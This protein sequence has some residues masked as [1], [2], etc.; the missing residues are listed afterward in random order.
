MIPLTEDRKVLGYESLGSY[1]NISHFV[2]TRRGGCSKDAYATFNCSPFSGDEMENVRRNQELLFEATS[3]KPSEL[4]IPHQ[5]H[6]VRNLVI[7]RTFLSLPEEERC[8]RLEGI[9][10]LMT[11]VPGYCICISTADCI[12][13]LLYDKRHQAIAAVHAGWRGTVNFIVGHTLE[14]MRSVYGTSGEEVVACI[15]PG[16]SLESFEVGYEVYEA[17]RLNSFD[18]SRISRRNADTGKYHI[19][20]WETNRQQ[21]LDF[22]VPSAQIEVAG[23][24]TYIHHEEFFSARR[25]GIASG[26]ILSGIKIIH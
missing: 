16:I 4:I 18:M 10:A 3:V 23:I 25:L 21:L 13:I 9:D 12:P 19:D 5:T 6:G 15:G 11:D 20:L 24:C 8:G 2:T 26:R 17:F 7:D 22:G 14:R 1:S